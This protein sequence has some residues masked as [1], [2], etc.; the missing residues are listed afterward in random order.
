[1]LLRF[2]TDTKSF[3]SVEAWQGND[4]AGVQDLAFSRTIELATIG[5]QRNKWRG[6]DNLSYVQDY[7]RTYLSFNAQLEVFQTTFLTMVLF[8]LYIY[9]VN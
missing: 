5:E 6:P 3:S 1:M 2:K 8:F 7:L 9:M 4:A